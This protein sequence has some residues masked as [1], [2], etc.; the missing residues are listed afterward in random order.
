MICS[1]PDGLA[2]P[3]ILEAYFASCC[4]LVR[5][6]SD[7]F[8]LMRSVVYQALSGKKD[9][10]ARRFFLGLFNV[11]DLGLEDCMNSLHAYFDL[12]SL[13][14]PFIRD[15]SSWRYC[16]A[17]PCSR[18]LLLAIA[19]R[20]VS[21]TE[22]KIKWEKTRAIKCFMHRRADESNNEKQWGCL[23]HNAPGRSRGDGLYGLSQMR[24][25]T[26]TLESILEVVHDTQRPGLDGSAIWQSESGWLRPLGAPSVSGWAL[27][28]SLLAHVLPGFFS[29]PRRCR[30]FS[31]SRQRHISDR[32]LHR[33]QK[34]TLP[35][36]TLELD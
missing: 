27:H 7:A 22:A 9:Q 18:A 34:W 21:L 23:W 30:H 6:P 1:F 35:Q 28:T 10:A 4:Q 36:C 20:G 11:S 13:Y 12:S 26:A 14:H 24:Q 33:T 17:V 25:A 5:R 3:L 15:A 31:R 29:V 19:C 8:A 2:L 16:E 32:G